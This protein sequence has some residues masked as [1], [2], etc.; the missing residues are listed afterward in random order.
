MNLLI[1]ENVQANEFCLWLWLS[2]M[3]HSA[4]G[5]RKHFRGPSLQVNMLITWLPSHFLTIPR[6]WLDAKMNPPISP[7]TQTH[8]SAEFLKPLCFIYPHPCPYPKSYRWRLIFSIQWKIQALVQVNS[9]P[10]L[11]GDDSHTYDWYFLPRRLLFVGF[12]QHHACFYWQWWK[13]Q[14]SGRGLEGRWGW[15]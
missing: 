8:T 11:G 13:K 5:I 12:R 1:K 9:M 3:A 10:A 4:K 14:M 15:A 6:D 7:H 2:S